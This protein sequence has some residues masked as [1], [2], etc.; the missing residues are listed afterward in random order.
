MTSDALSVVRVLFSTIWSLFVSWYIPGTN[1]TPG[2]VFIFLMF[3][4][5]V[6]RVIKSLL[7][8]SDDSQ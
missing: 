5:F 4:Y 3:A 7:A 6:V 2:A 8:R 1:V